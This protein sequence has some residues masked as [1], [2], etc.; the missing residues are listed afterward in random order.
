MA[1]PVRARP[2]L[3]Y[4]LALAAA[5]TV[6]PLLLAVVTTAR[7]VN[8]ERARLEVATRETNDR[9]MAQVDRYLAG[10]TAMLQALATSPAID[11]DDFKRLDEQARELLDLQ[12][13]NIVLRGLDGQQLIN[14]RVPWGT[15]L[16]QVP[17]RE[18]DRQAAITRAPFIS[19]LYPGV[20]ARAPLAR[21]IVPVIRNK[22]VWY[23]LTASLSP[24]ALSKLLRE[25]GV[26]APLLRLDCTDRD[27]KILARA[28][29]DESL[30]GKKLPGFDDAPGRSGTWS[31]VNPAG[32]PVYATLSALRPV[33]LALLGGDRPLRDGR[34]ALSLA[35]LAGH[36]GW[37]RSGILAFAASSYIVRQVVLAHRQIATAAAALGN[38]ELVAPPCPPASKRPTSSAAPSPRRRYAS[39]RTGRGAG[40]GE[41]PPRAA[42]RGSEPAR[43]PN[44]RRLIEATLDN[45]DQGLMLVDADGTVP[46]CNHR[47]MEL[48]DLP[49]ALMRSRPNFEAVRR[50]Q[51]DHGD[52]VK[53]DHLLRQW[54]EGGG[55]EDTPH[56][57]RAG[58]PQRHGARDPDG[59][60]GQWWRGQDLHGHHGAQVRREA[61]PSHGAP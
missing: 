25:A 26:R 3:A 48:L 34:A 22:E 47:A 58:A 11:S 27:G 61:L 55:I 59:A 1:R 51:L 16:P 8:S 29:H 39:A 44:R 36:A 57:L 31:G 30:V 41:P 28:R 13:L 46:I 33:E 12:G 15:T 17:V 38:G 4:V 53:S 42:G 10:K 21:I 14:T 50:F 56:Q 9:A 32:V 23:T 24:A 19:D 40:R 7:W 54:V 43:S 6:P 52:F 5:M 60:A 2:L 20:M 35:V 18:P 45:M 49:P 37:W